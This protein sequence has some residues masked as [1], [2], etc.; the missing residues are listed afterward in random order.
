MAFHPASVMR[1]L[2]MRVLLISLALNTAVKAGGQNL[3]LGV[4]EDV[5]GVYAGEPNSR[6]VRVLFQKAEKGWHAFPSKCH[7]QAC[8]RTLSSQYPREVVWTVGF[9]GKPLNQVTARTLQDF[10]FYGHV[11]FQDVTAGSV[12]T[13]GKKSSEYGGFTGDA[14]YRP[15]VTNSRAY[16]KDPQSWRPAKLAPEL[17]AAARQQFRSR[18]PKATNCRNPEENIARPWKYRDEDIKVAKA[19]S[20][21]DNWSLAELSLTGNACDGEFQDEFHGQWYLIDPSGTVRFLGTDMWLVD[22]GDYDNCGK[23]E[24][25]FSIDGDNKGGYKLF[26]D[27]FRKQ[28]SFEFHYH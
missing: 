14:V 15:L 21:N 20:S 25:L 27:D 8:L 10:R 28:E 9:D 13:V 4:L 19:Y 23:S 24:V 5:P 2:P 26:Y 6:H 3:V 22:A 1:C 17:V 12:P 16:F 7:D 18:F 11:G